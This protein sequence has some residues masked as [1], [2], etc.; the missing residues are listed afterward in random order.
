[1]ADPYALLV[2]EDAKYAAELSATLSGAG[3]ELVYGVGHA[4][5]VE[6]ARITPP[7]LLLLDL[8]RPP[9]ESVRLLGDLLRHG[10]DAPVLW[11]SENVNEAAIR[12]VQQFGAQGLMR[13]NS[14][15]VTTVCAVRAVLA[16]ETS[17]PPRMTHPA[18]P[19]A[20]AEEESRRII[21]LLRDFAS[22]G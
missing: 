10:I 2:I 13:K 3:I 12:R 11:L 20:K 18:T 19:D 14:D 17:F 8:D 1:M 15:T 9:R 5:A 7:A 21:K 16:G 4:H 6:M 22:K